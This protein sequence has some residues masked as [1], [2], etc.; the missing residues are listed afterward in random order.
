M[1]DQWGWLAGQEQ[2]VLE[3]QWSGKVGR[4][5][6]MQQEWP[7]QWAVGRRLNLEW[8]G[9]GKVM[10]KVKEMAMV[11]AMEQRMAVEW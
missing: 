10:G 11:M 8:S 1:E 4:R 2:L 3:F 5:S 9:L 6:W 7:E